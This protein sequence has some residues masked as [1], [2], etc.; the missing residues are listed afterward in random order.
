MKVSDRNNL[1]RPA[2]IRTRVVA[3]IIYCTLLTLALNL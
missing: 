2:P 3:V 1:I